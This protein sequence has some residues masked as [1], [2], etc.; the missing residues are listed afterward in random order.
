MKTK[1]QNYKI[2]NKKSKT[3]DKCQ[4]SGTRDLKTIL[5]L[6]YLPPVNKLRKINTSLEED[7]FYPAELMFSKSSKLVQLSTLVDKEI[8]FPKEYPYTS[9]TT[10]ILRE[11]F[12]ELYKECRKIINISKKD[13]IIDIGS[14]DGNLLSNFRNNHRVLGVTPE[15]IGNI[16][17]KRGIPTLLKYFD[18]FTS[19][20]I[21][22]KYGKAK[23]VTATNVFAHI[24]N[25]DQL[26]KNLLKILDKNGV[27]IS[28][29]HYLVSLIQTNQYDT[30]Y[31]EHLRYY[32]LES[33]KYL[34]NKYGMKIIHAK[35]IDTHGGSIRVYATRKNNFKIEKSV[36]KIL[37]FEKNFLTWKTFKKFKKNV[38]DS[39]LN[40]YSILKKLKANKKKIYGV[41]APSRGSTL[42]NYVGLD[43]NIID[44]ILEIEGSYKIGNYIPGKKIPILSEKKLYKDPPHYVIL[45]SWHI[46]SELKKNLKKRGY[47]GK[48]IIPLPQPRIED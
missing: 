36:A 35:K 1:V 8:L 39:K 34:F 40:L 21:V 5:S 2:M 48:F 9:S 15:K 17:I 43:E 47:K 10:K 30:I 46:A 19:N 33:L 37:N 6:G 3:I 31:H 25:V 28:E 4:I 42:I 41:G 38:V 7:S 27:F 26:M 29:S 13:L 44:C 18:K 32:S 22:K 11:N 45:F 20:L 24:E 12:K 23:I 16:A 14:N